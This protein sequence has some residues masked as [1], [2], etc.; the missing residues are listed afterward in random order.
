VQ[1]DPIHIQINP[2]AKRKSAPVI[3]SAPAPLVAGGWLKNGLW[4]IGVI[5][6]GSL[7]LYFL[8]KRK[9]VLKPAAASVIRK[10][11]LPPVQPA[12]PA[13]PVVVDPLLESRELAAHGDYGRF[14][15][16]VNRALWKAISERLRLPASELNKLNISAGLRVNGWTDEEIIQLK[17]L[18][19]ECEM[20]LYT[21]YYSSADAGHTLTEAER[22]IGKLKEA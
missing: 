1:S 19:N 4:I 16:A 13:K 6:I 17:Q 11:P 14:Y 21:P 22:I 3:T 2:G 8:L 10:A 12:M 18:M 20:K 5:L 7:G 15:S 9:Q